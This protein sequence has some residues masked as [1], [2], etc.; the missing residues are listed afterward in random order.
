LGGGC[1]VSADRGDLVE[2]YEASK[3]RLDAI[4]AEWFAQDQPLIGEGSTG[5]LVEHALHRL[6]RDQEMAT[7]RLADMAK[8]KHKGP[9]AV[10]VFRRE[11]PA[12]R[13]RR[14]QSAPSK[15]SP[16]AAG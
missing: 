2:L 3:E 5:Q 13:L 9:D 16:K 12:A 8:I 1:A 7:A 6:L 4:R 10:A 11:P 14:I 15:R